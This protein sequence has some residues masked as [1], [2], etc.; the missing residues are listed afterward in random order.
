MPLTSVTRDVATLT[1][2][3]VGDYPVSQQRLWDAFTDPRQLERF[4]GP[5]DYPVRFTRQE[6]GVGGRGEYFMTGPDG[7]TMNG[8]WEFTA[9]DPIS[10]F[11][12]I[13]GDGDLSGPS[14]I[15]FTFETTT[16]GSRMTA[17]THF[18]T[19]E[20]AEKVMQDMEDGLRAALPQLYDV[21]AE[22]EPARRPL[23]GG[24]SNHRD[25]EDRTMN[26]TADRESL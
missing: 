10:S 22:P 2:T 16:T 9:V 3:I 7:E 12:V 13:D 21:L 6:L 11:E 8:S 26:T 5:P 24:R 23:S 25:K 20:A 18:P 17:V 14:S 4:W 19:I 1:L 15:T